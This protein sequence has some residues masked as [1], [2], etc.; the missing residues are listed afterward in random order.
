MMGEDIM[1]EYNIEDVATELMFTPGELREIYEIYFDEASHLLP[2]CHQVLA[3]QD[4]VKFAQIMH[5]FKGASSNLRMKKVAG[6]AEELEKKAKMGGGAEAALK[7][8]CIQ[9]EI[10]AL[11]EYVDSFYAEL[12]E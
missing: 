3:C 6:M 8:P 5:G 7:L 10:D 12:E 9:E 2:D 1:L 4:Y 11:K